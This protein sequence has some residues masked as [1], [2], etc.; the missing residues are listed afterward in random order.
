MVLLSRIIRNKK[1]EIKRFVYTLETYLSFSPIYLAIGESYDM[2]ERK[3]FNRKQSRSIE[4]LAILC[5]YV[6]LRVIYVDILII[7]IYI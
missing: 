1:Y 4:I 2:N 7:N 5:N 6:T 3:I